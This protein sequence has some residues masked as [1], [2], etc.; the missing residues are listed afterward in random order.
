MPSNI[1]HQAKDISPEISNCRWFTRGWTLQELIAPSIVIFLDKEWHEIGTK[2]SLQRM[3]S[4]VTSIP[5]NIL[6]EGRP[7]YASIAQ[8]MS[9]ASRRET[10]RDEDLAYCL[11]GIFGINM[12]MIYGEGK[13]AFIR[14][15]EEIIKVSDDYSLF[16]W[17]SFD[18]PGGLL[19]TS[20]AA[21]FKSSKIIP[22]DSSNV[23]S[24]AI[25][26]NNKGI[27]LK[28]RIEDKELAGTLRDPK[29]FHL[30]KS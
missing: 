28:L 7:E 4:E 18:S 24:G 14:L 22:L 20:P 23:L 1:D 3:I 12:P 8:R 17:E 6:L 27:H 13:R 10:T 19:A 30:K 25:T 2:S 26:V 16:A 29:L 21:F 15:Q 9:W 5:A 11:M